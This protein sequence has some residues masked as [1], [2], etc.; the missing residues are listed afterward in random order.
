MN[1]TD[2]TF[3]D[4]ITLIT[5]HAYDDV[6]PI[7]ELMPKLAWKAFVFGLDIGM[8]SPGSNLGDPEGAAM[9]EL[10]SNLGCFHEAFLAVDCQEALAQAARDGNVTKLAAA[11]Q[12]H[13]ARYLDDCSLRI[14]QVESHR[15]EHSVGL[16]TFCLCSSLRL[17]KLD[18]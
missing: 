16:A 9:L 14:E 4:A 12:L 13:V 11:I 10:D 2:Q 1:S 18:N 8:T 3:E 5:G 6:T 15:M 7:E 17:V